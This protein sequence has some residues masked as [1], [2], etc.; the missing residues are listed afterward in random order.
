[1]HT[2]LCSAYSR[3]SADPILISNHLA[4]E[5]QQVEKIWHELSS[6]SDIK[7]RWRAL[8]IRCCHALSAEIQIE[9]ALTLNTSADSCTHHSSRAHW[10]SKMSGTF[11]HLPDSRA[12]Q[13]SPVN[14]Y[15][16]QHLSPC[17]FAREE[18]YTYC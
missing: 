14:L 4:M 13:Y 11:S 12:F 2:A 3:C 1:M 10:I 5:S 17:L 15:A 18:G 8:G 7:C 9:G 6:H 16:S